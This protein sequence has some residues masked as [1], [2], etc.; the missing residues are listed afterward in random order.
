MNKKNLLSFFITLLFC[1]S[2]QAYL[3][4]GIVFWHSHGTQILPPGSYIIFLLII[5]VALKIIL[6][7]ETSPWAFL[8]WLWILFF[9]DWIDRPYNFMQ[10]LSIRG[11]IIL[12]SLLTLLIIKYRKF[13]I[14]NF[15]PIIGMM[16]CSF[17][18]IALS[19]GKILFTDDH[20]T[21]FFRF[22]Q[23][24]GNFPNIPF[25]YPQWNA[26]T[27]A[28]DFFATGALNVFAIFSPII[29]AF[30]LERVYNFII[31]L[32][33]FVF[34]PL[35]V[36]MAARL[37]KIPVPGPAISA[38]LSVCLSLSWYRWALQYG[39]LGFITSL[40]LLPFNLV[41]V[42]YILDD[43]EKI[44]LKLSLFFVVTFTLMLFWSLSGFVFVPAILLALLKVRKL[45]FKKNIALIAVLVLSLN[46]PWVIS[47]WTVSNVSKFVTED[48]QNHKSAV[49]ADEHMDVGDGSTYQVAKN[50]Y[51]K[52]AKS[53]RESVLQI[54]PLLIILGGMGLFLHYGRGNRIF[55][56][57]A[58]WLAFIGTFIN[59]LNPRLELDRMFVILSM[60]LTLPA[61]KSILYFF[62]KADEENA[63]LRKK[64]AVSLIGG[65][66]ITSSFIS[67]SI[68]SNKSL[69]RYYFA[70]E[71]VDKIT[72]IINENGGKGRILFSGF[73]LHELS[74][75]HLA[76]LTYYT[77]VPL[78][79]LSHVHNQWRYKQIIPAYY[80]KQGDTGVEEYFNTFN[81]SGVFAHEKYWIEYFR[82]RANLYQEIDA[83]GR[84]KFFKRLA[85]H[86]SYFLEGDG[87]FMGQDTNSMTFK[88]NSPDVTLKYVYYNFLT[89]S[90]C[91]IGSKKLI[92][93]INLITLKNCTP[94]T[95]VKIKSMPLYKR[96]MKNL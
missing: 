68:A 95:I 73:V 40:A 75:G 18:F 28:R 34:H 80:L 20:T 94:G 31:I 27:D 15:M 6:K 79:A 39:T 33:L 87:E 36:Y 5:S 86:N 55:L 93:E 81:V 23:L 69:L 54:N 53:M 84:F 49:V 46:I 63:G 35:A 71:N 61:A 47:F 90:S 96:L 22:Q 65:F 12:F 91:E 77:N 17:S 30:P 44:S 51:K 60:L 82:S 9:S 32:L 64:I 88:I 76:P 62:E 21:F 11:E 10:G 45:I 83:A 57:T 92:D 72:S 70:N 58:I 1:V 4:K 37:E 25:Y 7:L 8:T 66:L 13:A 16:V 48:N 59:P 26:G 56:L 67:S 29:Y 78:M 89:S 3:A 85:F 42:S 52:A 41:C 2:L 14:F 19:E 50:F 74:N 38:S 43:R 24:K